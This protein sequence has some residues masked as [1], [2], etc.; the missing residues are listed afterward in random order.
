MEH[1]YNFVDGIPQSVT[2]CLRGTRLL[3]TRT[4]QGPKTRDVLSYFC[5]SFTTK[6]L[7]DPFLA[8]GIIT[9]FFLLYAL[10]SWRSVPCCF[11]AIFY[12]EL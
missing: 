10:F 11:H 2:A 6:S 7:L 1:K 3:S 12:D 8:L 4:F 9:L 5:L